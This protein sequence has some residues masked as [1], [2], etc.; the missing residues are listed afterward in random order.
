M[1]IPLTGTGG[2]LKNWVKPPPIELSGA[3]G[4]APSVRAVGGLDTQQDLAADAVATRLSLVPSDRAPVAGA[5]PA[6][7]ESERELRRALGAAR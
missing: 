1:H 6:P 4:Q 7:S 5:P 3:S 2:G